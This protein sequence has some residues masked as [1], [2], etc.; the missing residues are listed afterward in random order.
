MA[1]HDS[2]SQ[3]FSAAASAYVAGRPDY[4][5]ETGRWLKEVIGLAPGK[6]VLEIG[7]GT[8]KFL[9]FL[10][11]DGVRVL[12][13]EP[14]P[15][16]R[17]Q[18]VRLHP[19]VKALAGTADAIPLPDRSVDAI[20]CAQSFHWFSTVEALAE[21]RRVLIPG[22]VLGLIWNVRDESVPWVAALTAIIDPWEAGTP[23]YRSG[24]WRRLF[25][26]EGFAALEERRARNLHVGSPERVIV[27]R[28]LSTSFIAALPE[29]RRNEVERRT[30]ALIDGTPELSG[31]AEI[32]FPY[33]TVMF[34]FRK[35]A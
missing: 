22:G 8:G 26:A 6:S 33:D 5:K 3:G 18:L 34:A 1:V 15:A 11:V 4:P 7:A 16:M 10:Q 28:T 35:N 32:A 21:M 9:P 13:L 23:R 30:R 2:A 29:A 12:A 20:V 17:H 24:E 25:P 19:E 31:R 14:I 27:Q